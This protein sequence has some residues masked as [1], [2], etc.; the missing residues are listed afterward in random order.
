MLLLFPL[1]AEHNKSLL[2][3]EGKGVPNLNDVLQIHISQWKANHIL[4][5]LEQDLN[6]GYYSQQCKENVKSGKVALMLT[7][8]YNY[9]EKFLT[10]EWM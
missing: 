4:T 9:C 10:S 7:I 8:V 6:M 1:F 3:R 2:S 5:W